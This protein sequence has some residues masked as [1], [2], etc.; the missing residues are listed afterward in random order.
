MS[1]GLFLSL[2]GGEG[3]GKTVQAALLAAALRAS[4]HE[5]VL[6]REPGGTALGERL[7]DVVLHAREVPLGA[8]AQVLVF[9]AA[10]AQHVDEVI[11]PALEAGKVVIADRFLDSTAVYQGVGQGLAPEALE[12]VTAFA[13]DGIRPRRTFVL[14]VPVDVAG[15]RRLAE[16]GRAWDRLEAEARNSHE[17]LREGYL[18]LAAADPGRVVVIAADRAEDAI[19]ADIRRE[20]E[21][22]LAP[23]RARP[24]RTIRAV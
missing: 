16:R 5:V 2:E 7:R 8:R 10:R 3:S 17:R 22:L 9:S 24:A 11:R 23:A 21:S 1:G 4:G 15:R 6:T 18:R 20:V 14:D 19:A 12:A 13:V